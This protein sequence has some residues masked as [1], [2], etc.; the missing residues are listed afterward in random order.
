MGDLRTTMI[1]RV[2]PLQKEHAGRRR[3][4][5]KQFSKIPVIAL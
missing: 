1:C 4:G 3:G 5:E 2:P